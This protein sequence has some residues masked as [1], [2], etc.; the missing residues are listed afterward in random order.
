MSTTTSDIIT[1]SLKLLQAIGGT[2]TP[3]ADEANDGLVAFNMM[4]DSWSNEGLASYAIGEGSF[5][6]QIGVQSYTIGPG[7]TINATRP[8]D[9]VQAYV[10]DT[11]NNN[12]GLKIIPRDKWNEIGNRGST[13]TSQIPSVLFYDPQY[14]LGIINIFPTPSIAY[15][16]FYDN[17]T[18]Q[19]TSASLSTVIAMPPGYERAY[20]YNL[21]VE[22]SS[23][24]GI[25]IPP[26]APGAKNVGQIAAE[27]YANIKRTNIVEV[28]SEYD[29]AIVLRGAATYN[30]YRDR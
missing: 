30:I 17:T 13:I 25:P 1:R 22:I 8:F 11:G 5:P 16:C 15:T 3:K 29:P 2:E 26:A 10:R 6:L 19:V 21:A 24:F 9:I 23:M 12:F 14:P 20:V 7:G 27:A 28:I 18:N 4:L